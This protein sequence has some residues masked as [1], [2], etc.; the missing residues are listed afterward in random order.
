M[1]YFFRFFSRREKANIVSSR[2][3]SRETTKPRS[4]IWDLGG[5]LLSTNALSFAFDIGLRDFV[6]YP[7][8]DWK[9]PLTIP[10]IVFRILDL[11]F[12]P[13]KTDFIAT[14][15]G[16]VLPGVMCNW[17][18]GT[19]SGEQIC[20][21]AEPLIEEYEQKG[22]FVSNRQRR[23]VRQTLSAMFNPH[24]LARHTYPIKKAL[25]L[26][27]ECAQVTTEGKR[28]HSLYILSNWDPDSFTKLVAT[29]AFKKILNYVEP[30]N[31]LISGQIGAIKP[32][33]TVYDY[34]I[35]KFEVDP[36]TCILID[37]QKENIESAI[38]VGMEGV[39][40]KNRDYKKLRH[41]L[42]MLEVL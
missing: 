27:K 23:L 42:R 20:L 36:T 6:L 33:L 14:S 17:L 39:H 13:Q 15:Q 21:R 4:I 3:N 12:E 11:V 30:Q 31:I 10:D 32:E 1:Y 34:F 2:H 8:L 29:D 7:L 24:T 28:S 38:K 19:I 26:L 41:N 9:N 25:K 35:Q 37:D 16:K 22:Y 18:A 5:T 40:L